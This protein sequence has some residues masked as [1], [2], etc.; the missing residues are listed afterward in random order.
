VT[1]AGGGDAVR[2]AEKPEGEM[3]LIVA[4]VAGE[5][6]RWYVSSWLTINCY[7]QLG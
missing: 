5:A 6:N 1:Y 2:K 4:A 3:A 7:N